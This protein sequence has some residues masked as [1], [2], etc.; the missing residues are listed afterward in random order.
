MAGTEPEPKQQK[1]DLT[2]RRKEKQESGKCT[3]REGKLSDS[4]WS[5]P[6]PLWGG[7]ALLSFLPA[8]GGVL[9]LTATPL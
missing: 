8:A 3:R 5:H 7:P 1:R 2:N 6:G 4:V 9:G